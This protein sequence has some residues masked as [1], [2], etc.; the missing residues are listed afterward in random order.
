MIIYKTVLPG[1]LRTI[2][3]CPFSC[4]LSPLSSYSASFKQTGPSPSS[5]WP[6]GSSP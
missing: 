4:P 3:V 1:H 5:F 6:Q 2:L